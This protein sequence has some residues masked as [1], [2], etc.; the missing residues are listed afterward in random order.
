MSAFIHYI[1]AF[2][3]NAFMNV[4]HMCIAIAYLVCISA[5]NASLTYIVGDGQFDR[6]GL[7]DLLGR[8]NTYCY[9][10]GWGV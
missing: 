1:L 6:V 10:K 5:M 4:Y 7:V 3:F 9:Y 2:I 8:D